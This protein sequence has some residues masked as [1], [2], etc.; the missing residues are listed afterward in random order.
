MGDVHHHDR[1]R[2]GLPSLIF[3][4]LF[5]WTIHPDFPPAPTQGLA[6]PGLYWPMVALALVLAGWALTLAA[7]EANARGRVWLTRGALT[8][9]AAAT[10]AGGLAGLAG[11]WLAGLDPVQHV[12][13]AIVWVLALWIAVHAALGVVMQIFVLARSFAGQMTPM[14]DAD[15]RNVTVYHHFLALS[16]LVTF[17]MIG[18]FPRLA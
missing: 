4:Y 16:A 1:G 13:P 9:A 10:G 18:F 5:Y 3:G 8:A 17:L 11:P 12:Y 7:R 14:Y 6:G 2:Y 15:V